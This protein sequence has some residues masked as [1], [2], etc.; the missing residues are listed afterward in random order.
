MSNWV[1]YMHDEWIE[2]VTT[3]LRSCQIDRIINL[4]NFRN[5]GIQ[6]WFF[7]ILCFFYVYVC[8]IIIVN[9]AILN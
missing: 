6:S 8:W 4:G 7:I 2:E 5:L 3:I 9:G 1:I